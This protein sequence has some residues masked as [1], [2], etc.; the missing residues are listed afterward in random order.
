M[1]VAPR[2]VISAPMGDLAI[3]LHWLDEGGGF[4][5]LLLVFNYCPTKLGACG[6]TTLATLV[7]TRFL[8]ACLNRITNF[9]FQNK[10]VI[11]NH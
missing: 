9:L 1:D 5:E 11:Y 7:T 4:K 3:K 8:F 6:T 10:Y 2:F